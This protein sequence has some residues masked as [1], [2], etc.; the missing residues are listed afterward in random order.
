[1]FGPETGLYVARLLSCLLTA[2]LLTLAASALLV[3]GGSRRR[4]YRQATQVSY[5]VS[6]PDQAG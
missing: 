1:M 3:R 5:P 6:R 2:V 4:R